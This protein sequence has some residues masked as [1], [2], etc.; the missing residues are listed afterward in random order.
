MALPSTLEEVQALYAKAIHQKHQNQL[1]KIQQAQQ[2]L[3]DEIEQR[4]LKQ[5]QSGEPY[6]EM[7]VFL[8]VEEVDA[9]TLFEQTL[10]L[11]QLQAPYLQWR[12]YTK[13]TQL[14]CQIGGWS[15]ELESLSDEVITKG[16]F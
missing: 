3:Q 6:V 14:W 4:I 15:E 5:V 2:R 9:Q 16:A 13:H 10:F 11:L 7:K 1:T 8:I 12:F